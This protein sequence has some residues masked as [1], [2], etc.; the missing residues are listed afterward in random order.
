MTALRPSNLN[1]ITMSLSQRYEL[2]AP[3]TRDRHRTSRFAR[4]DRTVTLGPGGGHSGLQE[5][6]R[7][8]SRADGEAH[9]SPNHM[10]NAYADGAFTAPGDVRRPSRRPASLSHREMKQ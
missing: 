9:A 4:L 3:S 7:R 10:A 8:R 1:L 2:V 5:R 6:R